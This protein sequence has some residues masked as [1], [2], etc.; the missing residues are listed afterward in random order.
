MIKLFRNNE[1]DF[2]HNEWVLN[3]II[4][5]KVTEEL[6]SD[7][8]T[9]LQYPLE[10]KDISGNLIIGSVVTIPTMDN[11]QDQQF[12]IID[13]DTSNDTISVQMQAKLLADL[14]E[15]RLKAMTL[16]GMTRKQAIQAVLNAALDP[17]NYKV[18]NLDTNTNTNVIVNIPEG[19]VL[20]ALIGNENSILSEYGGEFIVNNNSI[21]I[22]DR[23][24]DD[25]GVVIEYGKNLSSISEKT[26]NIDLATV[27]IPKCGDYRLPEYYIES[28]NVNKYEKR[29]FKEVEL[30]FNIWDGENEKGE[31]QI[32]LA[33]AYS[34]MR[35]TCNKMFTEDK[36]DQITFN[37]EINFIELSKT[38]EYKKYAVLETVNL[39]DTVTVRHKKLNLDLQAR[40]NKISYT[41]DCEGNKTIDTVEIGFTRKE[42]TDIIKDTAKQIKFAKDEIKMQVKNDISKV[43][44]ELKIQDGKISAVVESEDGGMTWQLSKSAFIVACTGA[45]NSNVTIDANGLTVNNNKI[46]LKNSSGDTVFY[47]NTKGKCNADGGFIVDDGNASC[48]INSSG[49]KLTGSNGNIAKIEII[50]DSDYS[51]TYIRD[52]LYVEDVCRI[53][54]KLRVHDTAW[55]YKKVYV[56]DESLEDM[57]IRLIEEYAPSSKG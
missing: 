11:R 26:D 14:K 57:I 53:F 56:G 3:E 35:L 18:G 15:N 55:F 48:Y 5:C 4:E 54:G 27:L 36:V 44:S 1:I 25:N 20:N 17:H 43:N 47:V 34:L 40:V 28:P 37:Y 12:R 33:E 41:V 50:D 10:D 19:S 6:K 32:T 52:D 30:N 29:Y 51:G 16:T 21:D 8:T 46:R 42:I 49:I 24:G 39:G 13:K 22:I 23:R 9:E 38:E 45:S 31:D 7:Y 2:T